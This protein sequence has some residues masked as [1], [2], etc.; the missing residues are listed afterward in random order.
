[1]DTP[2]KSITA[3][4]L[5]L[6]FSAPAIGSVS[7]DLFEDVQSAAGHNSQVMIDVE[8]DMVTLT[9]YVHDSNALRAIEIS[10]EMN[11]ANVVVNNVMH[12]G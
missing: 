4:A 6:A 3:S 10:A 11:G 5:V 9:G 1:M 8:G 2:V 12:V 7:S